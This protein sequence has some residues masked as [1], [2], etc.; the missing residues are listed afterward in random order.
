MNINI[1][2]KKG[3]NNKIFMSSTDMKIGSNR[4]I[5]KNKKKLPPPDALKIMIPAIRHD[6]SKML[7]E[8]HNDEKLVITLLIVEAGLVVY[9]F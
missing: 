6:N 5:N 7:T 2:K 4:Y 1:G 3:C 8:K 9:N